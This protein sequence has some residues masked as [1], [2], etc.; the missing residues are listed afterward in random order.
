MIR[1]GYRFL[2]PGLLELEYPFN[3]AFF[4]ALMPWLAAWFPASSA[5]MLH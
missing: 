1:A 3:V 4:F 5:P 2:S